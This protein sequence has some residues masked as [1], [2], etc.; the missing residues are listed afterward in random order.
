MTLSD[1][2]AFPWVVARK[3]TPSCDHFDRL[4]APLD[5]TAPRRIIES[6][7]LTLMRQLMLAS[8]HLGCI[9]SF[10][11]AAEIGHGLLARLPF[12][13]E[14]APRPIG[15][16]TRSGWIPTTSQAELLRSLSNPNETL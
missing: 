11:V 10:Q 7:S 8:D 3:G 4:F 2:A 1:L 9:S 5:E 6:N 14:G 16:T 15:I 13:V 12:G